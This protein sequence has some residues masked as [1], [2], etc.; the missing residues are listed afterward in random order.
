MRSFSGKFSSIT[1]LKVKIMEEFESQ[2][3]RTTHFSVGYF[4]GG[5]HSSKEWLVTPADLSEWGY[6]QPKQLIY[7]VNVFL[8]LLA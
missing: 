6:H 8:N 7:E 1:D 3:P 5:R 4:E 2:V